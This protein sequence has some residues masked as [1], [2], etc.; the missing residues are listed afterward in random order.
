VL[1]LTAAQQMFRQLGA[2]IDLS[3]VEALLH[4]EARKAATPLSER[5]LQVLRLVAAGMTNRGIAEK[6]Y[7]SEKTVA[8]HIS[9]IFTKPD[10]SS[11]SAATAYAYDHNLV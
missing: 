5:E 2:A 6:L 9:N 8:R 7:I 11:R 4:K 3:Q 10:L 1:E